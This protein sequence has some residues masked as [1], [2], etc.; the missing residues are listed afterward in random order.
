MLTK[1]G[2]ACPT[3]G[4]KLSAFEG[5]EVGHIFKLGYRYT[6]TM[7]VT[8]LDQQGKEQTPIMGTY[9]IGIDRTIATVV[10]CDRYLQKDIDGN[11]KLLRKQQKFSQTTLSE[12]Q[13]INK[14]L[15]ESTLKMNNE[16][17]AIRGGGKTE[18]RNE[19]ETKENKET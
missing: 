3:C 12:Q 18:N 10:D 16:L 9:G 6:E 8:Y 19:E 1:A 11:E 14:L 13:K 2:H 15:V 4:D 7:K 17:A 5:I